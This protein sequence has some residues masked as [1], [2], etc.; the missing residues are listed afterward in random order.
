ML[1]GVFAGL[2]VL[3][4]AIGIYGVLNYWVSVR[5]REVAVRM[6]LGASRPLIVR[7]AGWYVLRLA[8]AGLMLGGVGS[9]IASQWLAHLV[10]GVSSRSPSAMIAAVLVVIGAAAIASSFPIW[11][12]S[13]VDIGRNLREA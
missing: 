3:L 11:R 4:A 6:A 1:L 8:A 12:A 9:W 10:Y 2:A 7:W 13:R 5:N